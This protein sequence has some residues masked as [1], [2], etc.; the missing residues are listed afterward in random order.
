MKEIRERIATSGEEN[1]RKQLDRFPEV[2]QVSITTGMKQGRPDEQ[3]LDEA[4]EAGAD[5]IVMGAA[6]GTGIQE[7]RIGS[8]ADRVARGARSSVL[9]VK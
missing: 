9:L 4:H 3:I 2:A 1:L 6:S 7:N 8:V 5:L